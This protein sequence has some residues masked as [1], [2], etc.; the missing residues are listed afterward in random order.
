MAGIRTLGYVAVV[1]GVLAL[2]FSSWSHV[3]AQTAEE[4]IVKVEQ[5]R[6]EARQKGD[7]AALARLTGDDF[8]QILAA[9]GMLQKKDILALNSSPKIDVRDLQ[10]RIF[11]DVAVV[12]GHQSGAGYTRQGSRFTHVWQR[13]NGQWVA[14]FMQNTPIVPAPRLPSSTAGATRPKKKL[15]AT[16]WPTPADRDE[17]AV[18]DASRRLDEAFSRKNVAA[19]SALTAANWVRLNLD[20][21]EGSREE[22]LKSVA[23]TA[24]QK[25]GTP[26]QSQFHVRVYGS[27]AILTYHQHYAEGADHFRSRVFVSEG[28]TWKQLISQ[29]TPIAGS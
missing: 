4:E 19:Y 15:S 25:R 20:G 10:T 24:D 29:V 8:T 26:S 5:A 13:R 12:T 22:F 23:G 16:N 3:A 21:T 11:G 17:Q 1:A 9:G 28:G 7:S 18:L 27:I 2:T 6:V 14:V